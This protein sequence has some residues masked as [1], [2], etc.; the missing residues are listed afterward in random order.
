MVE[1]RQIEQMIEPSL[2]AMGYEVVRVQLSGGQQRP[3]LQIMI[4]RSDGREIT[5]DDCAE[6]SR[7]IS[8]LLDV[9][10]P[11]PGAYELEVS[12]P[13][14]DR[15]LTRPKDFDRFAGHL[16]RIETR[17]PVEGRKRFQGRLVGRA[18]EEVVVALTDGGEARLPMTEIAKA[19]LVLTDELIAAAANNENR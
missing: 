11:L 19:K 7:A 10:D 2:A 13:G 16:A 4:E 15:P 6:S 8:A 5:V 1:T 12:S 14:I 3:T 9:E 17:R 18:G